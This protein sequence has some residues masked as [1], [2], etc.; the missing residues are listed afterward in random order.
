M[1]LA[2]CSMLHEV[3]WQNLDLNYEI[4]FCFATCYKIADCLLIIPFWKWSF[5]SA[6]VAICWFASWQLKYYGISC[7]KTIA[8]LHTAAYISLDK[9]GSRLDQFL[10][11]LVA[12]PEIARWQIECLSFIIEHLFFDDNDFHFL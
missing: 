11:S 10:H 8:Y 12:D 7:L 2:D 4:I 1:I 9:L 5:R 6:F 3:W